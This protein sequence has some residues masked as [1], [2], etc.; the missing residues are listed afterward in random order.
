MDCFVI[1]L[2]RSVNRWALIS[3]QLNKLEIKFERI[4]ACDGRTISTI[5]YEHYLDLNAGIAHGKAKLT[6]GEVGCFLSHREC[7]KRL[8][9][10][11]NSYAAILEDD[12][13]ISTRAASYLNSASWIPASVDLIM[14]SLWDHEQTIYCLRNSKRISEDNELYRGIIP[15]PFGTQGYIISRRAAQ[16]ALDL[17]DRL[18]LPVDEFLFTDGSFPHFFKV[19]RMI[20]AVITRSEMP[21]DIGER[22]ILEDK[23]FYRFIDRMKRS[24]LKR[25]LVK[26]MFKFL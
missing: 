5:D 26:K 6:P 23:V 20:N 13:I 24:L 19:W 10:S 4:P 22:R 16:K 9:E 17:S 2:D 14:L 25:I 11:G 12:I 1:N 18:F 3:K 7:W 21:S 15:H 8:V